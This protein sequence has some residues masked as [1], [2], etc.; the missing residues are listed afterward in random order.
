MIK[1]DYG[2]YSH[3][4]LTVGPFAGAALLGGLVFLTAPV[5]ARAILGVLVGGSA[6]RQRAKQNSRGSR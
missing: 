5:W 4:W 2:T 6:T 1:A 3:K